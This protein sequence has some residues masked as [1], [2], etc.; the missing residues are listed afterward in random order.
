MLSRFCEAPQRRWV[1]AAGLPREVG[2]PTES[3]VL[4]QQIVPSCLILH[5]LAC[6]YLAD[7][8]VVGH[9][10]AKCKENFWA[11][12]RLRVLARPNDGG[13]DPAVKVDGVAAAAARS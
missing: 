11:G 5:A 2:Q 9:R 13:C 10:S 1:R 4:S 12:D 7:F 8:F 6:G 3:W